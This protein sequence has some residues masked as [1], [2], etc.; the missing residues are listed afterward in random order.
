M[1][2]SP[3]ARDL[4]PCFPRKRKA[5]GQTRCH[6]SDATRTHQPAP[7][8]AQP[9]LCVPPGKLGADP[10]RLPGALHPQLPPCLLHRTYFLQQMPRSSSGRAPISPLKAHPLLTRPPPLEPWLSSPSLPGRG[11]SCHCLSSHTY[12]F[13]PSHHQ[14]GSHRVPPAACLHISEPAKDFSSSPHTAERTR[15]LE[16]LSPFGFQKVMFLPPPCLFSRLN[17]SQPHAEAP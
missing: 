17:L 4:V 2:F 12:G 13:H 1:D 9:P 14:N 6:L 10:T 5:T 16:A 3:S 15:L 7:A 11:V 8:C